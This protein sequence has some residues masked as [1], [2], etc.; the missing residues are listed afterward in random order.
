M[1]AAVA[2]HLGQEALVDP[3]PAR[4][5]RPWRGGAAD[6]D[7][8]GAAAVA[9]HALEPNQCSLAQKVSRY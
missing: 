3:S 5:I 4:P 6:R 1:P 8:L 2:Q 7:L 9:A